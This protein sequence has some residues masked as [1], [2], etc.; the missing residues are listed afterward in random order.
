MKNRSPFLTFGDLRGHV[1]EIRNVRVFC[2]QHVS[3]V[4]I[5]TYSTSLN[6]TKHSKITHFLTTDVGSDGNKCDVARTL[7]LAKTKLYAK[8]FFKIT[9][10]YHQ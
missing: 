3:L 1:D 10:P 9:H 2:A 6:Q 4:D 8:K 5:V 7:T